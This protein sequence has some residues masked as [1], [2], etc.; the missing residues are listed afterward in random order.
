MSTHR[1]SQFFPVLFLLADL[2]CLN[3]GIG[4]A[5]YE[6]FGN[7]F[8]SNESYL[9]LQIVL[10]LAW[11]VIFIT[12][13]LHEISRE[14]R[15]IDHLNK[16]LTGLV[17]NLSVVFALWFVAKPFY[18][19][20]QH[21]FVTYLAFTLLLV[22]WRT[23]W[24]YFIRYYRRKGYNIRNVVI[25]G[26]GEL[27]TELEK[28]F[29]TNK[30]VGY[31]FIGYFDNNPEEARGRYLGNVNAIQEYAKK[32]TVDVIFCCLPRLYVKEIKGL[33]DFAENN[34]IKVKIISQ[35]SRLGNKSLS[36]QKYGDIPIINVGTI[37]L[38]SRANQFIKRAFDI[39]FS[40]LVIL[41][42]FSWLIPIIGLLIR[43]ESRGPIFFKQYR[44]GRDNHPFLCWKFRTMVVNKESD[45]KQ[46]TKN[47]PRITKVGAILRKTSIDEL[48]QFINVFLGDMSVVGPRPHPIKLNEQFQ[49]KIDRFIQRHAVKPGITGLAQA[50]GFRGETSVFS[51]MSGRVRLDRFYVKNWS[52]VLDFKII[53][54]TIISIL[55]GSENAY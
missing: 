20:R 23:A 34:L 27:A 53:L 55:R 7:A 3:L 8:Y 40:G 9:T 2:V 38:D 12:T 42:I 41:F 36:I 25:V 14:F 4:F 6:R 15:L 49:P 43:L 37:P 35:F 33:I 26:Y 17:I 13:K 21:L 44:N 30:G 11:I 19:S 5:N 48:P 24:H 54:L 10:N 47:D 39:I 32:N 51:D 1:Y 50:K 46:A 29:R 22:F 28:Y 16:V 31:K 45:S 52:L 18:Y